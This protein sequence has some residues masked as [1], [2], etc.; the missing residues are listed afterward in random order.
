VALLPLPVTVAVLSL[1]GSAVA[2]L[3]SPV[4]VAVLL[5]PL[6]ALAL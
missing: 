4:T 1:K 6:V 3:P 5:S 2:V